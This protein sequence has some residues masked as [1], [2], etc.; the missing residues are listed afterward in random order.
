MDIKCERCGTEYEFDDTRV[1]EEGVTVKCS[2]C[3]HLFKVR[4]KSFVLTEPVLPD[5]ESND[6]TADRNWMVRQP[7]GSVLSFKELT[8]LQKWIVERR[9]SRDDEISKS[10]ETWK[11][12]GSIAELASFFQIVDQA[13]SV[14][15]PAVSQP[16]SAAQ[17]MP[18]QTPEHTPTPGPVA[19]M[20]VPPAPFQVPEHTPTPAPMAPASVQQPAVPV[21]PVPAQ[22]MPAPAPFQAPEHTPAPVHAEPDSWGD[23]GYDVAEDDVVDDWRKRGRRKWYVIVPILLIAAGAGVFYLAA[24]EQFMALL[25]KVTGKGAAEL[26]KLARTQFQSGLKHFL[27]DS[28]P[29]LDAAIKDLSNAVKEAKGKY[30]EAMGVLAEVYIT[31]AER[32]KQRAG[33]LATGFEAIDAQIAAI[34]PADANAKEELEELKKKKEELQKK[35]DGL[36]ALAKKDMEDANEKIYAA[37]EVDPDSFAAKRALA[38]HLRVSGADRTQIEVPLKEAAALSRDDPGL[39]FVD[40]A[41]F[42]SDQA[43]LDTAVQ[44]LNRAIELQAKAGQPD[45]LRARY[46]LAKALIGLKRN[47]E[48]KVQLERVISICA[49]HE[50]AKALLASLAPK[51]TEKPP[52]E[53]PEKP[54]APAQPLSY[55]GWMNQAD[56]LQRA[57]RSVPALK[58]YE[59]ALEIKPGDVEA[60]SGKGLCLL[61]LGNNVGAVAAFRQALRNNSKYGDAIIGLAE[62]YKYKH[63][64]AN[65]IKYYK[66][67][68]EVLPNGPESSVA[69]SNLE[70][71]K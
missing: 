65:A 11:R 69:R 48:A 18:F 58:A 60:I 70:Q 41:S 16:P 23:M 57:G 71:L 14:S 5:S 32:A 55:D 42:A 17:P 13:S 15:I 46:S 62:A 21:Q 30:P 45:L 22:P 3:G 29:E 61:D 24:P 53:K 40:G 33:L 26:P 56:R 54:K 64:N 8:T 47:D 50:P 51:P 44:K 27:M 34:K 7:D 28:D 66:R 59:E 67:Y 9:V 63:D 49:G 6:E 19:Q 10:G 20:P 52:E 37:R 31:R 35:T 25:A 38:N 12:L 39:L 68:L 4:K 36:L 43:S 1:N 2:T